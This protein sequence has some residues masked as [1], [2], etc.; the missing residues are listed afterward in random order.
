MTDPLNRV[1]RY[2]FDPLNRLS[3]ATDAAGGVSSTTYDAHDRPVSVT[4]ANGA[5][6]TYAY[7]GLGNVVQVSSPD[8]GTTA[9][10]YDLAGNLTQKVDATGAV[11]NYT[12]D[13]L[14]RVLTT[15][16]PGDAAENVAYTYDQSGH[17]FGVGR[18]T[19]LTD[20]AGSLSRS[21]DERGNVL[22]ETRTTTAATLVTSYTYD[23]VGRTASLTYPS[24]DTATYARDGVGQVSSV[25]LKP[26]GSSSSLG[27][28]TSMSYEP[29]GSEKALTYG[30]GLAEARSFD[31]DYR[32]LHVTSAGVMDLTY[33]YDAADNVLSTTDGVHA[34]SNQSF[35]YD[36]L[37]RLTGATG[38]YGS[39]SYTYDAVGNRLTQTLGGVSTSFTY[40]SNSNRLTGIT[41]GGATQTVGYTAAGN[42]SSFS[43]A[44]GQVTNVA[45]NQAGRTASASASGLGLLAYTYDAFGHRLVKLGSAGAATL[46][47]YDQSGNLLS[48]ADSSGN[49]RVEY[50]Y[51]G[52]RPLATYTPSSGQL[53]FLHDDRLGTPQSGTDSTGDLVWSARYDPFGVGGPASGGGIQNLRM[54]GQE[55]EVETG[56]NHNGFRDYVPE[57]GRYLET[58]PVGLAGGANT[59]AYANANP[60]GNADPTGLAPN[61][62]LPS[63]PSYAAAAEYTNPDYVLFATHGLDPLW[64]LRHGPETLRAEE[65]Y[66]SLTGRLIEQDYVVGPYSDAAISGSGSLAPPAGMLSVKDVGDRI[67]RSSFNLASQQPVMLL[68]CWAGY[69]G[70]NSFAAQV[71]RYLANA[72]GQTVQVEA[73]SDYVSVDWTLSGRAWIDREMFS[74]GVW[75]SFTGVPDQ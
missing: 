67:L 31:S 49:S 24:G 28:A 57:L 39:E 14:D 29:F 60:I 45:Y 7:D 75:H 46:Y 36:A 51:A 52:N 6:T 58:D 69:G 20:A 27:V 2:A 64:S 9:Y 41:S 4:A 42:I 1:A 68:V 3:Q 13:A 73:A 23:K 18:L 56:W 19:S 65:A 22:T 16:Y 26:R 5:V 15:T 43:P 32:L 10:H 44:L 48:E 55:F 11:A 17:G 21:Y 66:Y 35:Q 47:Q 37:N 61:A 70:S 30:N 8:S 25:S 53:M 63:D 40:A 59:F 50:V 34:G 33:A 12:Y 62:L 72:T 74:P 71:A 54:P 38:A